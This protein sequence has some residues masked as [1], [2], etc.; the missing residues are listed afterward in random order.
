MSHILEATDGRNLPVNAW[1]WGV[2]HHLV[3]QARVLPDEEWT[4]LRWNGGGDLT[5]DQVSVLAAFLQENIAARLREGERMFCDGSVTN[6]PD[7]GILF[8]TEDE[9]W[10]NYSLHREV[11]DRVI[12][13]LRT[14]QGGVTVL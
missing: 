2:L 5:A 3:A 10:K 4:P 11:L 6:V 7:D 1:N 8:R 14:S 12:A 13:F 9:M